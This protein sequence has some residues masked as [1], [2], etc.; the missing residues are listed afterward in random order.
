MSGGEQ[1]FDPEPV[2]S[3]AGIPL[4]APGGEIRYGGGADGSMCYDVRVTD[5][6]PTANE[7]HVR[8]NKCC[9]AGLAWP[10]EK[11]FRGR[12]TAMALAPSVVLVAAALAAATLV[13]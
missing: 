6:R 10:D 4:Q 3:A 8:A 5:P 9:Y 12:D 13:N 11:C 1:L 7:S 2:A